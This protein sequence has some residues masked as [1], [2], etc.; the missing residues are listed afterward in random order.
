MLPVLINFN[1]ILLQ[2][3]FGDKEKELN[4]SFLMDFTRFLLIV[5]VK[6]IFAMEKKEVVQ[7]FYLFWKLRDL[8]KM[9]S[10]VEIEGMKT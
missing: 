3:A 5:A 6:P 1:L 8:L 7:K 4:I 10:R 9:R 2:K